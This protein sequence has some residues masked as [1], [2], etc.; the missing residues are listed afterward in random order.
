MKDNVKFHSYTHT[1]SWDN[2]FDAFKIDDRQL[3]LFI[4][5]HGLI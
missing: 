5:Y 3:Y 2:V 4:Q 1:I